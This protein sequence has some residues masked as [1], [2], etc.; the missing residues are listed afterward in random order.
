MRSPERP[1]DGRHRVVGNSIAEWCA[2][3]TSRF[4][5]FKHQ[6]QPLL[7]PCYR[8]YHTGNAPLELRI[9]MMSSQK[10]SDNRLATLVLLLIGGFVLLLAWKILRTDLSLDTPVI[11]VNGTTQE[12]SE[13]SN[14]AALNQANERLL[15]MVQWTLGLIIAVGGL[16][17][18]F[19]WFQSRSR[20]EEDRRTLENHKRELSESLDA[21]LR[22]LEE[23]LKATQLSIASAASQTDALGASVDLIEVRIGGVVA[24]Y[25]EEQRKQG[26]R[27]EFA[28]LRSE[29]KA[30]IDRGETREA[31]DRLLASLV[32]EEDPLEQML[33]TETI[34]D[35]LDF[36]SV[37]YEDKRLRSI[38]AEEM[39]AL[40]A[41]VE[42]LLASTWPTQHL[43]DALNTIAWHL[44]TIEQGR[45]RSP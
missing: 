23:S 35:F 26:R 40:I 39:Q 3:R 24:Q 25:D 14:V 9:W 36:L 30:A 2:A 15:Q 12:F 33:Y 21:K 18:G 10:P 41:R 34:H 5:L 4:A 8:A 42:S 32:I 22:S 38:P 7:C 43:K 44:R 6:P 13:A 31:I 29:M 20:L 45:N 17:V 37:R 16:L 19:S 28:R 11:Q 27:R 1:S